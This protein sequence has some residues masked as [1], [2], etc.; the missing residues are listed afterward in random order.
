M[1]LS[2]ACL[3]KILASSELYITSELE[4]YHVANNWI[5]YK[6]EIRSKF[7]KDL[8]LKVRL[9]L[10]SENTLKCLLSQSKVLRK[11]SSFHKNESS[12]KMIESILE[13]KERFYLNKSKTYKTH[14]YC[15]NKMFN[16]LVCEKWG[17]NI[18]QVNGT[19]FRNI[20][21]KNTRDNDLSFGTAVFNGEL[22]RF[23]HTYPEYNLVKYSIETN[24]W[25][26]VFKNIKFN[27]CSSFCAFMDKIIVIGGYD[28][29]IVQN[30]SL[31]FEH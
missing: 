29:N 9:P 18:L 11:S 14:R 28:V 31:C 23:E 22:Y 16:I 2:F 12:L 24:E 7:A 27:Y 20:K 4:V 13:D 25:K 6:C 3:S 15:S 1:E 8:L 30:F 26:I 19:T 17:R 21:V 5:I 10:L